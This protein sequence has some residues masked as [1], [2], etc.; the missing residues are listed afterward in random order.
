[1]KSFKEYRFEKNPLEKKLVYEFL[2]QY[3]NNENMDLIVFGHANTGLA[4]K[5][6]LTD[7]EKQIVLSVIQWIGSP[8]GEG[9]VLGVL[10]EE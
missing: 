2:N 4:P 8:V 7:R 5:E 1:M 10:N 6:Y 9:F 3:G